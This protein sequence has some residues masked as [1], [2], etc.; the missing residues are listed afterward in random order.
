MTDLAPDVKKLM[1]QARDSFSPS[2]ERIAA[3]RNALAARIEGAGGGGAGGAGQGA[4]SGVWSAGSWIGLGVVVA[5]GVTGAVALL[6]REPSQPSI[7]ANTAVRV[8]P[9]DTLPSIAPVAPSENVAP[10]VVEP[11]RPAV[12]GQRAASNKLAARESLREPARANRSARPESNAHSRA[13]SAPAPRDVRAARATGPQPSAAN[14][15]DAPREAAAAERSSSAVVSASV[16]NAARTRDESSWTAPERP[17]ASRAKEA[18]A[19]PVV[20]E[21]L[22]REIALLRRASKALAAGRPDTAL[23]LTEEHETTFPRGTLRQERLAAR[24]LALCALGRPLEAREA[25]RALEEMAP[26][27]PHLMRIRASCAEHEPR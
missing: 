11:A 24:A 4:A 26:R 27:S 14:V 22:A 12:R 25:A 9:A 18:V 16:E 20:D 6:D 8:E 21:S 23:A 2:E 13:V 1:S 10:R 7:P 3:V 19:P 17:A 15:S 5:L